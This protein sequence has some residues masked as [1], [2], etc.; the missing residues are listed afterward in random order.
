MVRVGPAKHLFDP[1]PRDE[2]F[3][4]GHKAEIRIALGIFYRFDL[5]A[6]LIDISQWLSL[7]VDEGI[8]FRE[9]LILNTD[10]RDATLLELFH[11]SPDV[12]EISEPGVAIEQNGDGRSV[13]HEFHDFQHLRPTGFIIVAN[14]Q[15]RRNGQATGPNAVKSSFFD[16]P[17]A[18][19]VV[20][21]HQEF[22]FWRMEEPFKPTRFL[23][24]PLLNKSSSLKMQ[25]HNLKKTIHNQK[26]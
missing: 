17:R 8:R 18:Q 6:E 7:T 21:L 22:Q 24:K 10:R 23:H 2:T 11:Q 20:R 12:V 26:M 5:T 16:N 3:E 9:Q 15:R 19:A 4:A 14:A 1:P 25:W 13:R